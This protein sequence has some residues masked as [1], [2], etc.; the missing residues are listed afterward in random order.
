MA[1][2]PVYRIAFST[3]EL[4]EKLPHGDPRWK[5]FN[6][7]F[8]N[9]ELTP[10]AIGWMIDDGRAFTTWHDHNWRTSENFIC[11]QHLGIDFDTRSVADALADPF[12]DTYAAIVYATPSSTPDAPRSRALFLLDRPIV[13]AANYVRAASALIWSF[14]GHADRQCKDAAR[15]FYGSV[16]SIPTRRNRVLPLDVVRAMIANYEKWQQIQAAP[17][18]R[19]NYTPRTSDAQDAQRL[20]DRISPLRADDYGDWVTVGMALRSLGDEGLRLW[21]SW[22]ARSSKH[23]DGECARKWA[24]FDTTGVTLATLGMW[25]KQDSPK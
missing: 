22:S 14:G 3:M 20:L 1:D 7:S 16:A 6:A 10:Y 9:L 13:Q 23:I 21:D 17:R 15:F 5:T 24:T 25:A 4:G 12:I 11:G 2:D 19:E 18:Q 8:E